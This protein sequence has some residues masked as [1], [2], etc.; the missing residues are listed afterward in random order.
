VVLPALYNGDF[1]EG[2]R[3]F[4]G[5]RA[6][7][8]PIADVI[9]PTPFL[10]FQAAFDPLN[11]PGFR[12]YWKSHDFTELSDGALDVLIEYAGKLPTAHCEIFMAHLGGAVGRVAADATAY[13]H[14]D[15]EFVVN[16]HTRWEDPAED[17][18]CVSWAR[19]FFDRSAP[20]ATGGVYVNF[21]PDDEVE[22]IGA[23]YGSNYSRL[24]ELKNRYDP[25]NFFRL[26]Q[27]IKPA[28]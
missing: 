13:T 3:A 23:A 12:N 10:D 27:N 5:L 18:M 1:T 14:R 16:V 4:E 15:A 25:D 24:V 6:I 11:T 22:R 26:N 21:M 9:G 28:G 7:G 20:F 19:E 2:E 8:N 17:E